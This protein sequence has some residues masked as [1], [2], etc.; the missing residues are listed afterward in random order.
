M[1]TRRELLTMAGGAA[2][3]A[4]RPLRAAGA[5]RARVVIADG[6][7]RA[8]A[9]R[10]A[11]EAWGGNPV[12]GLH[13]FV[14]ANYNSADETPGSTHPETLA[15]LL[16]ALKDWGARSLLLG[17]RSGMGT[18]GE[19]LGARG[20]P[21]AA[22]RHGM[23]VLDL[24][25]A[26]GDAWVSR[27]FDEDHWLLGFEVARAAVETDARIYT[28]CLKTHFIARFTMALKLTVGM[29]RGR[30]MADLHAPLRPR[31]EMIAEISRGL[32]PALVLMDGMEAFVDGGPHRGTRKNAGVFFTS[33]DPVALDAVGLAVLKTLGTTK[34]IQDAPIFS[35]PQIR[36][37]GEL[38]VGVRSP[39]EIE[40]VAAGGEHAASVAKAAREQLELG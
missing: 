25:E 22:K 1:F 7:T 30:Y 2:A 18:T 14:K 39:A 15:A 32:R 36:R 34:D 23:K 21:E 40:V 16:G 37:A 38:G 29:V 27:G 11:L 26:G 8:E 12:R 35:Q 13:A 31:G 24:E 20:V 33:D 4:S 10:R 5:A 6:A 3:L 17:E 9:T 19:V 28:C